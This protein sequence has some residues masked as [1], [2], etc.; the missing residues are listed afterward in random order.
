MIKAMTLNLWCYFDWEN[1]KDNITSLIHDESPDF[2]AFQEVQTNHAF[3]PFPQSDYIAE[4]AGYKYKIF[5]PMYKR[6]GQ[7]DTSGNMTQETSYGLGFISKH[8]II[9]VESYYLKR[10]PDYDEETS[11]LFCKIDVDSREIDICNVHFGNSDLFSELHLNELMDLCKK[12]NVN[13][14]ILGDFNNFDLGAYK[15]KCLTGYSLSTDIEKYE[16][17]PKNNGTLDYIIVP[18]SDFDI[19]DVKCPEIY[20]SDHRAV[21]ADI[22]SHFI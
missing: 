3:S 1:R 22:N 15:Q 18:S 19:T 12:R 13:P 5:A 7:I 2:L 16:S 11:V 14:I 8:P 20:V 9:S 4:S 17:M 21:I 10:H 6:D